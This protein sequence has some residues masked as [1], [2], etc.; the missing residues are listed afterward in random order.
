MFLPQG[1]RLKP[2][3]QAYAPFL[4][5]FQGALGILPRTASTHGGAKPM[6]VA[7]W[8]ENVAFW[9]EVGL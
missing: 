4:T 3:L 9:Y 8:Y 1:S 2:G 7:F 5:G 6:N